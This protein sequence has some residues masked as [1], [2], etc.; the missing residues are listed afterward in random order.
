MK[1]KTV[2]IL[3]SILIASNCYSQSGYS[4]YVH[5]YQINPNDSNKLF[6]EIDN[7]NF[8]KNNE[9]F[10]PVAE[11]YT[12]LGFNLTPKIQYFPNSR[13]KLSAGAN[14]LS[15]YGR[16]NEINASLLLSFQYKI[17]EH[18][19][20][21]LGNIYGTVNHR[22]IEPIYDF[23]RFLNNNIENGIQFLWNYDRFYTDLWLDWEQQILQGDPFQEF[24]NV[25]LSS[26]LVLLKKEDRYSL[27]IP[28]QNIVR[29]E[30]GQINSNNDELLKTIFNNATGLSFEKKVHNKFL[31]KIVLSSYIVN[32]QDLSPTKQQLY[33]DGTGFYPSIELE[34]NS[35]DFLVGYWYGDQFIAPLGNP[36]FETYSR[37]KFFVEE[38]IRQ[39]IT[40]KLSYQ[41]DVFKG[42]NLSVRLESYYD[43]LNANMEYTWGVL[44]II[45]DRFFLR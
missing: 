40:S 43:I 33:I 3:F 19:D 35:F 15:Y 39:V 44:I 20:F 23:E 31:K 30:G 14:L 4:Y 12:L 9:Y 5:D 11:G 18:F 42:I 37:T 17:N 21:V 25:G 22:L 27:S 10:G 16:E 32:Y 28:F 36:V 13:I 34:N 2:L 1:L 38:P 24:F 7:T 29:H 45:N 6:L 41:K 26:E 8:I